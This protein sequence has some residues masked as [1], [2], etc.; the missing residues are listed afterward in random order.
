MRRTLYDQTV[1]PLGLT[2]SQWWVLA[3]LSRQ[4]APDGMLQTELANILDVGKVSIGG[5][6][7][8]LEER[9]FVERRPD[10]EDRRAKRVVVTQGGRKVLR[11]MV[12]L[13]EELNG[14]IFAGFSDAEI[15]TAEDFLVR[16]KANVRSALD[17]R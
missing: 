12:R 16:M 2:R 6:V 3:Q 8:R 11:Q 13:S 10:R 9:G 4:G 5:L 17:E 14:I 15:A 1:K 7:D